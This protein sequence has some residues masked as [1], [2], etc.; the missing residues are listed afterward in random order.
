MTWWRLVST[1]RP[2]SL[3]LNTALAIYTVTQ[4]YK[5][6]PSNLLHFVG[7]HAAAAR[8][9]VPH[10]TLAGAA[11]LEAGFLVAAAGVLAASL[12]PDAVFGL[13]ARVGT[14][15]GEFA[16]A[17]AAVVLLGL[18]GLA[19]MTWVLTHHGAVPPSLTHVL[20]S[21]VSAVITYTVLFV[22]CGGIVGL[23]FGVVGGDC[24]RL[25]SGVLRV[26]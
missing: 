14:T 20:I 13:V 2:D 24:S 3:R 4:S 11:T 5:Y 23:L 26:K 21:G 16:L 22:F 8:L 10:T 6:L 15:R 25:T 18:A 9:G 1:L 7:R 12:G 19:I 17:S